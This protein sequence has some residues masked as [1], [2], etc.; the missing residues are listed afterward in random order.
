MEIKIFS[1]ANGYVHKFDASIL[2]IVC[3]RAHRRAP[4]RN[5]RPT[6]NVATSEDSREELETYSD[7]SILVDMPSAGR[8]I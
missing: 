6:V 8:M 7:N 2:A 3:T 1:S 5:L 4:R